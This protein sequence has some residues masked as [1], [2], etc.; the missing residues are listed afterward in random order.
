[1]GKTKQRRGSIGLD[2][3]LGSHKGKQDSKLGEKKGGGITHQE[4]EKIQSKLP[5]PKEVLMRGVGGEGNEGK[6]L[7]SGNGRGPLIHDLHTEGPV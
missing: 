6:N 3:R 5:L 1:M 7:R 2:P 4:S